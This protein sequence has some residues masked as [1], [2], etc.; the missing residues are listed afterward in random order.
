MGCRVGIV[1]K[2][3]VLVQAEMR[4]KKAVIDKDKVKLHWNFKY[5]MKK[6]TIAWKPDVMIECKDHKL[7]QIIDMACPRD[8]KIIETVMRKSQE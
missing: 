1:K 5:R 6:K 2:I 4:E 8:Q 7:I 3:P